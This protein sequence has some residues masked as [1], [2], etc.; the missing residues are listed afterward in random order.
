[1]LIYLPPATPLRM[2]FTCASH[3]QQYNCP[4]YAQQ[5]LKLSLFLKRG[6]AG[7]RCLRRRENSC[8]RMQRQIYL[9][10]AECSRIWIKSTLAPQ[11][12]ADR[13]SKPRREFNTHATAFST[14]TRLRVLPLAKLF[15]FVVQS[16]T[17]LHCTHLLTTFPLAQ[18]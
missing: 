15:A 10:Y 8:K 14:P 11:R 3:R 13:P 17:S 12:S 16:Q 5:R 6:N 18:P 7:E 4:S 2:E 1:M 9:H